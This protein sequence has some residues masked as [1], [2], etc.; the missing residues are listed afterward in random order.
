MKISREKIIGFVVILI[1]FFSITS[2]LNV[3]ASF[4]QDMFTDEDSSEEKSIFDISG[5]DSDSDGL[6]DKEEYKLGTNPYSAD[7]DEDGYTDSEEITANFDPLKQEG[8]NLIDEDGDGL[9]GE[10]EKKYKT[11]PN[12]ADTDYDGYSD[13]FEVIAGH[14]PLRADFSFLE[15]IIE[16][17]EN[18]IAEGEEECEGEDCLK[19]NQSPVSSSTPDSIE[20][21]LN[22]QNF[23]DV[24]PTSLSSI[25]LDSS[26]ISL[27]KSVSVSEVSKD[28]IKVVDNTSKEFIQIYF[29]VLGII[30]YSNSPVRNIEEAESYAASIN[31]MNPGQIEEMKGIILNIRE[32]FEETEVPNKEEFIEYHKKVLGAAITLEGLIK[33]LG[34]VDSSGGNSFYSLLNLLPKFSGFNDLIFDSIYPEAKRLAEENGV[35]LPKK[36]FLE[37]YK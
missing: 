10:D 15:P 30:L 29:N 20:K 8:N 34:E 33:I 4:W 1:A 21:L 9:T 22:I 35:E 14:D 11:N 5:L 17:T 26:K 28:K 2:A 31:I 12:K 25:G 32:E 3:K 6:S 7:S 13:G 24:D 19:N 23:S 27:E 16:G 18:V 37:Q 36:E